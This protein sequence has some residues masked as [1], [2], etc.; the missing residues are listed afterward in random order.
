[1]SGVKATK[2]KDLAIGNCVVIDNREWDIVAIY[3]GSV[4]TLNLEARDDWSERVFNLG[5]RAS[6]GT[7]TP[8]E[9]K[10]K[11]KAKDAPKNPRPKAGGKR[12]KRLLPLAIL[13]NEIIPAIQKSKRF[14]MEEAFIGPFSP[15]VARVRDNKKRN[16]FMFYSF[17][18]DMRMVTVPS[19]A[20]IAMVDLKSQKW[21]D[22]N[23]TTP[24]EAYLERVAAKK[25]EAQALAN[26]KKEAKAKAR[27]EVSVK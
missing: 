26:S 10:T 15:E 14:E 9:A 16:V 2:P 1:M 17:K 22:T 20:E 24:K 4:Y 7:T 21:V 23:I 12:A 18:K 11:V 8:T 5:C 6:I 27:K 3:P 25:T 19:N 13:E